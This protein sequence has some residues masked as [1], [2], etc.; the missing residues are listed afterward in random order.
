MAYVGVCVCKVWNY[1]KCVVEKTSF[2]LNIYF[3]L[4]HNILYSF[5]SRNTQL[6]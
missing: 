3:R 2:L 5:M 6:V 4:N 1:E